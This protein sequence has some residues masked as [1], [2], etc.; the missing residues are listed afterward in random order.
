MATVEERIKALAR[1]HLASEV[2]ATRGNVDLDSSF[3][4][5]QIS[6][7]AL[8]SFIILV[9]KEFNVAILPDDLVK[10]S[11]MRDLINHLE[12]NAG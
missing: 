11:S 12:A 2:E 5:A 9:N 6:S 4:D 8:V 3:D 1:E 10:F 7:S